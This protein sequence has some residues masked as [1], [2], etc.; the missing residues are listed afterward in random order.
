MTDHATPEQR[1]VERAIR[2]RHHATC[3]GGSNDP[4]QRCHEL[5]TELVAIRNEGISEGLARNCEAVYTEQSAE[6]ASLRAERDELRRQVAALRED[7]VTLAAVIRKENNRRAINVDWNIE[8]LCD[9]YAAIAPE[10]R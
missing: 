10:E 5:A 7:A 2:L 1:D 8:Q 4:C 6:L 3:C 9:E